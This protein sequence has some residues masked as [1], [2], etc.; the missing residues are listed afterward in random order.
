[1]QSSGGPDIQG[2]LLTWQQQRVEQRLQ[3]EG[4]LVA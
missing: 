1:M 4:L 2:G 3:L